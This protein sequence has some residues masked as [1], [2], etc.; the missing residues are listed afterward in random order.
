MKL[1]FTLLLTLWSVA[2]G[3]Q[4]LEGTFKADKEFEELANGYV[5]KILEGRALD[6][7]VD[8]H[9][10][11][12]LFFM[13]DSLTNLI[14]EVNAQVEKVNVDAAVTF[15]GT[16]KREGNRM[17]CQFDKDNMDVSVEHIE[18]FDPEIS[19]MLKDNEDMVYGVAEEKLAE[20]VAPH[21][22]ELFKA[23][24][25]FRTYDIL[26]QT[27][28]TLRIRLEQGQEVNLARP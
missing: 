18:S 7:D 23:T 1:I 13:S 11:L 16:Y 26:E 4:K 5:E 12:S 22:D 27:E 8:M 9:V 3:A 28:N 10:G 14:I 21:A 2:A 24:S 6:F 25:Y 20:V 19:Q 15:M 17:L